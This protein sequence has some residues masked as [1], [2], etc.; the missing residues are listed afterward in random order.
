MVIKTYLKT[1]WRMFKK[2]ITRFLS[3][4]FMVLIAVSFVSGIGSS[5]DKIKSSLNDYYKDRT[6]SDF[7]IKSTSLFGFTGQDVETVKSLFPDCKIQTISS[8][9]IQTSEKRS[10]RYYFIDFSNWVANKPEL[11]EGEFPKKPT[12]FWRSVRTT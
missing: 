5:T 10:Q 3:L 12:R 7:I 8:L 1:L 2:H 9:D 6:V 11:I 4:L